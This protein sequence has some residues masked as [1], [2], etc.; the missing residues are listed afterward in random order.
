MIAFLSAKRFF[1]WPFLPHK[2][3][4]QLGY[5]FSIP[6]PA[7]GSYPRF[8]KPAPQGAFSH[9]ARPA[10]FFN[11]SAIPGQRPMM[12]QKNGGHADDMR[13]CPQVFAMLKWRLVNRK[14]PR[15]IHFPYHTQSLVFK[16]KLQTR[17]KLLTTTENRFPFLSS[18]TKMPSIR[19]IYN[20][21]CNSENEKCIYR[22]QIYLIKD[23]G[24]IHITNKIYTCNTSVVL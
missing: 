11:W 3:Q 17:R 22:K 7:F 15:I 16:E 13:Q 1:V 9:P 4:N 2:I 14:R 23:M 20:V 18:P 6:F 21:G 10:R 12:G 19:D 5:T 8:S 24:K